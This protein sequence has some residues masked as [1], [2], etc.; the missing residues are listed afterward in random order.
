MNAQTS[1][2]A[3]RVG[4]VRLRIGYMPAYRVDFAYRVYTPVVISQRK[5]KI[6][7]EVHWLLM[8]EVWGRLGA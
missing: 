5:Y 4:F 7:G 2:P 3:Y 1:D 6:L 8:G